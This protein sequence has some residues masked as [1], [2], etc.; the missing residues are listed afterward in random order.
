MI[1]LTYSSTKNKKSPVWIFFNDYSKNSDLYESSNSANELMHF[2]FFTISVNF[3]QN[4]DCIFTECLESGLSLA[5]NQGYDIAIILYPGTTFHRSLTSLIKKSKEFFSH[6]EPCITWKPEL[7]EWT[8]RS[9]YL[10]KIKEINDFSTIE[11]QIESGDIPS[12]HIENDS[13]S[14]ATCEMLKSFPYEKFKN[15]KI[16]YQHRTY[17]NKTD[18]L[19]EIKSSWQ[20]ESEIIPKV[21]EQNI[22]ARQARVSLQSQKCYLFN[23]ESPFIKEVK[24]HQ[25]KNIECILVPASGFFGNELCHLL[26]PTVK[27]I[28]YYDISATSLLLKQY[29]NDFWDGCSSLDDIY[30]FDFVEKGKKRFPWTGEHVFNQPLWENHWTEFG[31]IKKEYHHID[32]VKSPESL[33]RLISNQGNTWLWISNIFF[34]NSNLYK[35]YPTNIFKQFYHFT[36]SVESIPEEIIIEGKS[37]WG[38]YFIS[39]PG[40]LSVENWGLCPAW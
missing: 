2:T 16:N 25:K 18:L 19:R 9:G 7:G 12:R 8:R 39:P 30:Q 22:I 21:D 10:L 11:G 3:D 13:I 32:I 29:I 28:I 33:N 5:K 26:G 31:N 24:Q 38:R 35:S 23:N 40:Q 20:L 14:I 36:E 6:K 1:R 17:V 4:I 27:K 37:P 15:L 34:F